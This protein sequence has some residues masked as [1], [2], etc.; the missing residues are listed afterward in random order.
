MVM[1]NLDKKE[2]TK[3]G[4]ISL[5]IPLLVLSLV[6][7]KLDL[8]E[9]EE[10]SSKEAR[11]LANKYGLE[12]KIVSSRIPYGVK[13]LLNNLVQKYDQLGKESSGDQALSDD[14]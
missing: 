14:Y 6:G 12:F 13:D 9:Q 8:I 1:I 7:T 5:F 3:Q 2:K 4:K 10:V 11:E